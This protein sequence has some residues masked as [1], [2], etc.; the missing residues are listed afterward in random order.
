[1]NK[2]YDNIKLK[3]GLNRANLDESVKPT[4]DFY[5]Y[6]CGGWMKTHPL[7]PEFSRFGTF[8]EVNDRAR[9]QL[10]ELI[11]GLKDDPKAQ[12]SGTNA[13]KVSDLYKL[14]MDSTRLNQE[15]A[16]P[17]KPLLKRVATTPIN[18][19]WELV[20]WVHDGISSPFFSTGVS[21]DAK[22]SCLNIMHIGEAG[23]SLGDR[24]YYIEENDTNKKIMDAFHTYVVSLMI[25]CDYTQQEAER[26]WHNVLK[27]EKEIARH[28]MTREQRRDPLARYHISTYNDLK[29]KYS[30][31]DW[32]SY[33]TI[34]NIND[35]HSV[36]VVS[37]DYLKFINEFIST[38]SEQEL[39][40]YLAYDIISESTQLL[41]DS[42]SKVSFELFGR[43]MCGTEEQK[44]R[45]K[46]AMAIPNSILG[47]AVGQLYVEKYFPQ[48]NKQYMTIMVENLRKALA[49]HI[50]RL[51]WMSET[52]K[53]KAKDKLKSLSVKIGFPDT[54]KDYS[55]ISVN[56]EKS[57][58]ENVLEASRWYTRENYKKLNQQVDKTEWHMTPQTVNAYYSPIKNEICFPAGI[59]QA[60][61]FDITADDAQNYGSIGVVIGHEMTHGFD[62]SGR[63]YDK[64]GN[65]DD[66]WTPEDSNKFT[67]LADNLV[68]QFDAIEV[69]PGVQ[70]NGRFTL[71]EN[72]A[73]QGGIRIALTAYLNYSGAD[74]KSE[75]DGFSPLKR[76]FISYANTWA[77]N[78]R[79]EEILVRT[80]TDPHSLEINRVNATLR[81]IDTFLEAFSIKE[82]DKMFRPSEERVVIW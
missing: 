68:A 57:Y 6:A 5:H 80:K 28:K 25:L 32:Q 52:T 9:E 33:F 41:S 73:D 72:I 3:I 51:S 11:I 65:L 37:P 14:G 69:A 75:I 13:Q 10:R 48:E 55:G 58:L 36:N 7:K 60:P 63:K 74:K 61:Y 18:E 42:F 76:F 62:D 23:L 66:W 47:E 29:D 26:V 39:K 70:A 78:I 1:M 4:E 82:G 54:W 35:L 38:L 77:S 15:G 43:V 45:W 8:D 21:P 31:I 67:K 16:S 46:R 34:L 44:P 59:L 81:N 30:N 40:D 53:N 12:I 71:G 19:L 22:N 24:D 20:A 17:L 2:T 56:P 49:L 27:I 50:D 64:D 79:P